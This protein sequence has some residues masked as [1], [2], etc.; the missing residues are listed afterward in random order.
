MWHLLFCFTLFISSCTHTQQ[1]NSLIIDT[2]GKQ[3]YYYR[4]LQ[5]L[6]RSCN[7]N[8]SYK[9][10]YTMLESPDIDTKTTAL[11]FFASPRFV[12][13]LDH[14]L[15]H[16]IVHTLKTFAQAPNKLIV[17]MLPNYTSPQQL[18]KLIENIELPA[19]VPAHTLAHAYLKI[20]G[21]P[22]AQSGKVYGTSLINKCATNTQRTLP[23]LPPHL[24]LLPHTKQSDITSC[25]HPL[26]LTLYNKATNNLIALLPATDITFADIA[27][28][29]HKNPHAIADR[30]TLLEHVQQLLWELKALH[31]THTFPN[32][33]KPKLPSCFIHKSSQQKKSFSAAWLE[34]K[35]FYL[36]EEPTM[37]TDRIQQTCADGCTFLTDCNFDLLWFEVNPE[38]Y[39]SPMALFKKDKDKVMSAMKNIGT[40]LKKLGDHPSKPSKPS[41]PNKS[42]KKIPKIFIGSDITSNFNGQKPK[43]CAYD[44]YGTA[45]P[46]VPSPFDI[47]HFWQQELLNTFKECHRQLKNDAPI[48]GLFL[49]FEMY[50]APKQASS[51]HDL[52]DFSEC[53]W[54][55]FIGVRKNTPQCSSVK[56]RVDYLKKNK[57]F[58]AY[59]TALTDKARDIGQLITQQLK[60]IDP[61]L[62]VAVYAPTLPSSWFY[63]GMLSGLSS[64][65]NPLI[66]AT[67]NT[68]YLLHKDWLNKQHIHITHGSAFMMSKLQH[69]DDFN[70]VK[71]LSDQ[72]DF[73][74]YNRPSRQLYQTIKSPPANKWWQAEYSSLKNS[75]IANGIKSIHTQNRE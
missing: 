10:I 21:H 12:M 75:V 2:D 45:Y 5:E 26:A 36:H 55:V 32:Q 59:F 27:E 64:K 53:A 74:W 11:F 66:T 44:L 72:H 65:T 8:C 68:D 60:A 57:L 43:H 20:I 41:K 58:N 3:E 37:N 38:W 52:M 49:D 40:Q 9:N 24:L 31:A 1:I 70:A 29:F 23:Q 28:N 4:V 6:A 17:L 35:D 16:D 30:N 73:M 25:V 62:R 56:D 63:R 46:N 51:Y 7:F 71:K 15:S 19:S 48:D 34:P 39:F 47:E 33:K 61:S 50:Q 67:F 22:N 14:E 69:T 54:H 13:H 18:T 42:N